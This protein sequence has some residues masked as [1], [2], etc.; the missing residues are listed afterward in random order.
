M[1][2]PEISQEFTPINRLS[3]WQQVQRTLE[4]FWRKW[5]SDYFH[6]LQKI[7]KWFCVKPNLKV[8]DMVLLRNENLPP[9]K[10]LL[11]R[12]VKCSVGRDNLIRSV[13][14]RTANSEFDR[15]ISKLCLLP[16]NSGDQELR[17]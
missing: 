12:I 11:G 13:R 8:G 15:P 6:A 5:Y 14:V 10:W 16:V 1:R 7:Y 4:K 2:L 17:F 9:S 3:R